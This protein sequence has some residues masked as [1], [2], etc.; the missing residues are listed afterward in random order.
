[1]PDRIPMTRRIPMPDRSK[2]GFFNAKVPP[3]AHPYQTVSEEKADFIDVG[4]VGDCGFRALAVAMLDDILE[5]PARENQGMAKYLLTLHAS[6]FPQQQIA[7]RLMTPV[8][9]LTTL[10]A[11]PFNRAKFALELSYALRQAAVD[12]IVASPDQ[13]RGAFADEREGT[14][15]QKMRQPNTWIDETAIAALSNAIKVP[16]K[17]QVVEPGKEIPL[18]LTYNEDLQMTKGNPI[19]IQLQGKHYLPKV[20]NP[21]N[22]VLL[23]PVSAHRIEPAKPIHQPANDPTLSEILKKIEE[24][25]EAMLKEYAQTS[26]RLELMV[27]NKELS[28]DDLLRIYIEGIKKSDY[29]EGRVKQVG[30]EN[31]NQDFFEQAIERGRKNVKAIALPQGNY[32]DQI[33]KELVHAI[34]RAISI[35]Q[36]DHSVYEN[37]ETSSYHLSSLFAGG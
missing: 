37:V 3:V 9:H 28:K 13:Y 30:I 10:V 11:A 20:K 22:F 26:S 36:L 2:P 6:Y 33:T 32:E 31:G 17:V 1:M 25:D 23:D 24:A 16:I 8:E 14:D 27:R 21:E 29:L 12:E 18:S 35:G 7:S 5:S 4:G 34:A 15:P 19:T